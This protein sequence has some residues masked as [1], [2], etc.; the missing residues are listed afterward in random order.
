M[1]NFKNKLKG[2]IRHVYYYVPPCPSCNSRTTGR[3][4]KSHKENTTSW[5]INESLKHGELIKPVEIVPKANCFCRNCGFE[6]P[7]YI[8]TRFITT[9]EMNIEKQ[10]R[11]T[12]DILNDMKAEE[13]AE[14][15]ADFKRHPVFSSIKRF[16]GKI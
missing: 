12:N 7:D 6:W 2:I 3:F 13:K 4:V 16:V 10:E 5:Q 11:F 14:R 8:E 9:D 15:K 1:K